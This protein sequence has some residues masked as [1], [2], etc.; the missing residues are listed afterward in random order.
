MQLAL[1]ALGQGVGLDER[2]VGGLCNV[3]GRGQV[4]GHVVELHIVAG[5]GA[6]DAVGQRHQAGGQTGA[7]GGRQAGRFVGQGGGQRFQVGDDRAELRQGPPRAGLKLVGGGVGG[8]QAQLRGQLQVHLDRIATVGLDVGVQVVQP[9]AL[10]QGQAAQLE[11]QLF[12]RRGGLADPGRLDVDDRIH[13]AGQGGGDAVLDLGGDAVR[14]V[15]I[16]GGVHAN[17]EVHVGSVVAPAR[18]HGAHRGNPGHALG[19]AADHAGVGH[20]LV[21]E[22]ARGGEQDAK[23]RAKQQHDDCAGHQWV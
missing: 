17:V 10:A 15:G 22:H 7:V 16:H 11:R 5:A 3:Q 4:A 1:D 14:L 21:G 12:E 23:G 9:H 8:R 13:H 2:H 19:D 18:A 20:G 6:G